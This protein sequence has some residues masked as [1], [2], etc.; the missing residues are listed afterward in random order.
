MGMTRYARSMALALAL[1]L[2]VGAATDARATDLAT[3]VGELAVAVDARLGGDA[4]GKEAQRLTALAKKLAKLTGSPLDPTDL[5]PLLAG[6][7]ASTT[8]DLDVLAAA[9]DVVDCLRDAAVA[10][11]AAA[12]LIGEEL[13]PAFAS[14][15]DAKLDAAQRKLDAAAAL[16]STNPGKAAKLLRVAYTKFAKATAFA[17]KALA[18]QNQL[19]NKVEIRAQL[20][21]PGADRTFLSNA[22]GFDNFGQVLIQGC[23][24]APS[25]GGSCREVLTVSFSYP[26]GSQ[27][28]GDVPAF[29]IVYSDSSDFRNGTG[30]GIQD[31]MWTNEVAPEVEIVESTAQR[32]KGRFSARLFANGPFAPQVF[33]VTGTFVIR[34]PKPL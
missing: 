20:A 2:G 11:Q 17:Q 22:I 9:Q 5:G 33:D 29:Q 27:T 28:T 32:L 25:G 21:S 18:R 31:L 15:L 26:T 1:A 30:P 3:E 6:V 23:E 4:S 14:K 8:S 24:G 7:Y 19:G 13:D 10:E 16:A 12:A 34:R